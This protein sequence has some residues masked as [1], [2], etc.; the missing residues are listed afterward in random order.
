MSW[1]KP[2]PPGHLQP[3]FSCF[4]SNTVL[5]SEFHWVHEVLQ[6]SLTSATVQYPFLKKRCVVLQGII[7]FA[8]NT[9]KTEL[10]NHVLFG[11]AQFTTLLE[12]H[13]RGHQLTVMD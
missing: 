11:M 12:K 9:L 7:I 13:P 4:V 1:C 10:V 3:E 2:K 5:I 8:E 6:F